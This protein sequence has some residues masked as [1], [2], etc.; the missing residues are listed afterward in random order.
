M[1]VKTL[2]DVFQAQKDQHSKGVVFIDTGDHEEYISYAE[3]FQRSLLALAYLQSEAVCPGQEL[4]FQIS[5]NKNF[6][7]LFWACI[8]GGIIPVPL[9]VGHNDEHRQKLF[10]VWRILHNPR[11]IA[12][13][14]TLDRLEKFSKI[15][16][17][18]DLFEAITRYTLNVDHLFSLKNSGTIYDATADDLAFIQFSSGST[19]DPKGVMLTHR[20][21]LTTIGAIASAANYSEDDTALSWMPLTHDMGII[22]FHINPLFSGMK[23]VLLSTDLFVRRPSRWLEKATQHRATVLCSPNFGYR[24]TLK[25]FK[26]SF[27]ST[28][29]LSAVRILYNGAEPLS[30]KLCWEFIERMQVFGLSKVAMCPVYGLA[31]ASLAVSI[32]GIQDPVNFIQVHRDYLKPG[33]AVRYTSDSLCAVSLVN[34]GRAVHG[35]H[36][37]ILDNRGLEV[38]PGVVGAVHIMGENVTSGYYNNIEETRNIFTAETWLNTGDLGCMVN[39]A[40]FI[41][42][43]A[44]DIIFLNGQNY[45]PNDLEEIAAEIQGVELNKIAI[46][47]FFNEI[48]QMEE[49]I[50]FVFYRGA[51]D[52][53]LPLLGAIKEHV[54]VKTGVVLY[55]II[56]VGDIPKTTSGKLQRYKMLQRYQEKKYVDIENRLQAMLQKHESTDGKIFIPENEWQERIFRIWLDVLD[57]MFIPKDVSFY[58]LGGDSLKAA[59]LASLLQR[60]FDVSL[61]FETLYKASTLDEFIA[62]FPTLVRKE[63]K[64]IPQDSN[65]VYFPLSSIQKQLYYNWALDSDTLAYNMPMVFECHGRP[66][67]GLLQSSLDDLIARH[68]ALRMFFIAGDDPVSTVADDLEVTISAIEAP[69]E[70]LENTLKNL[71]Q[72]FNLHAPGL[73]RASLLKSND[74]YWL[75]LDV[76]HIISDGTSANQLIGEWISLYHGKKLMPLPARYTDFLLWE[77][78]YVAGALSDDLSYWKDRLSAQFHVLELPTDHLR[79]AVFRAEGGKVRYAVESDLS[80]S[81]KEMAAKHACTLNTLLCSVYKLLLYKYTGQDDFV[82]GVPVAGRDHPDLQHLQGLFVNNLCLRN[83]MNPL[84]PFSVFLESE[85]YVFAEAFDHQRYPFDRLLEAMDLKREVSK[86]QIFDVMFVY[87]SVDLS[88][89]S[90]EHLSLKPYFL[91][92][93]VSKYDV[94]L[95][96]VETSG[97]IAY[98]I[99]YATALF[100]EDTIHRMAV[101]YMNLLRQVTTGSDLSLVALSMLSR[102][103]DN[104]FI[105]A[106]NQTDHFFP[107]EKSIVQMFEEQVCRDSQRVAVVHGAD[108]YSYEQLER[109]VR[110]LVNFFIQSGLKAREIVVIALE[111][112]FDLVASLLAV[113]KMGATYLPIDPDLPMDRIAYMIED[114]GAC[115]VICR[116]HFWQ[117]FRETGV[118]DQLITIHPENIYIDNNHHDIPS[119]TAAAMAYLMYT[120]GTTG[121]PKAVCISQ[122]AL[123]NYILSAALYYVNQDAPAF[124]L[125]TS[126]SF[127]L[128][129]TSIFTPLVTGGS[130]VVYEE[131]NTAVLIEKILSDNKVDIL[132]LTPSHLNQIRTVFSDGHTIRNKLRC[133]IVGGE[134][135]EN[136]LAAGIKKI[137][138]N[139]V[140]IFNEYGPTEATVGCMLYRYQGTEHTLGVPIG[141][142]FY[143]MQCYVLD[144]NLSLVP[145]GVVGEL[146][147]GGKGLAGGYLN[148]EARSRECFIANPFAPHSV[149]YKTGDLVRHLSNGCIEYIGRKD[150]QIK[151]NGYRI[152]PGEIQYHL[153]RFEGVKASWVG[154]RK[155]R[156]G[157]LLAAY[158]K[159]MPG[160]KQINLIEIRNYLAGK[161]PHYMVPPYLMEIDEIPLTINGKVDLDKLP[162]PYEGDMFKEDTELTETETITLAVWRNVLGESRLTVRDNFFRHGGDSIKA[163][164][165]V[166]QLRRSGLDVKVKDILTFHDVRETSRRT[167]QVPL[168]ERFE[169]GVLRGERS[170][171]PI[172]KWFFDNNFSNPHFYNQTVLLE[173]HQ[174]VDVPLL[175]QVLAILLVHHDGLRINVD[176]V[177]ERL[178]YNDTWLLS[179]VKVEEIKIEQDS[180][181]EHI[182]HNLKSQFNL[183]N[184]MLLKP[185]VIKTST[186]NYLFITAHHLVVDGVSWRVLLED[187]YQLYTRLGKERSEVILPSKTASCVQWVTRVQDVA[188]SSEKRAN[189]S[190]FQRIQQLSFRIPLD[191]QPKEWIVGDTR[192]VIYCLDRQKTAYLLKDA[193]RVYNTDVNI[194]LTTALAITLADW[195]GQPELVVEFEHHGRPHD[196]IDLSRTVGWFTVMNLVY[197]NTGVEGLERKIKLIKEQVRQM[198]RMDVAYAAWRNAY[199]SVGSSKEMTMSEVRFNYLG[200]FDSAFN[201]DLFSLSSLSTGKDADV[202]NV[203]TTKLEWNLMVINDSLQVEV[204]YNSIAHHDITIRNLLLKFSENLSMVLGHIQ[205]Q[206]DIHFTPSD[207]QAVQIDQ[208]ELDMLFP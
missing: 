136:S 139:S 172:E 133:L 16:N 72:P 69:I 73:F 202:N 33:D 196:E 60:E 55:R 18:S 109:R 134:N 192:K 9:T 140:E 128:T 29:D 80:Y 151:L 200:Q 3:L 171:L 154:L 43:R 6:V 66:D 120:S 39:D 163:M 4:V 147:V 74:S 94:T 117:V 130:I 34:V 15:H 11:M 206:G 23:Q 110:L 56:P 182:S 193:H 1:C 30:L 67:I 118:P 135:L 88:L 35:C 111:R 13:K 76:H 20:N 24:Y 14:L 204:I 186:A 8:L 185:A 143:N 101:H 52:K 178:Y 64:P 83:K 26:E 53:F 47:G 137:F 179:G 103:E 188:G 119:E 168:H 70:R 141:T 81:L 123:V 58:Q 184:T 177:N 149:L 159:T 37:S 59:E 112:S 194:V 102:E 165:I 77:K 183:H 31:E 50:A 54:S 197:L 125:F 65:E 187:L 175:E 71:I 92:P 108:V 127:D 62:V 57:R 25:H 131:A 98:Y 104:Y 201:N 170:S 51:L 107:F 84:D 153:N 189:D 32:S 167:V 150:A 85:K 75:F 180:L 155:T 156:G 121:H 5:D 79:P 93:G 158:L 145:V 169:Q 49:S 99:E 45:Y 174:Q 82:I 173:F 63:Y 166:S 78:E 90:G 91:D 191:F 7:V 21:V 61:T 116:E 176:K 198:S 129:V 205:N 114:S 146:Y 89:F 40:L 42:G 152:E 208:E 164:Q 160:S 12:D 95:E 28:L 97:E 190:F 105:T 142:P 181:P 203:L 36:I 132:K 162:D 19:G 48:T 199:K 17:K 100:N 10:N 148:N 161:L 87:R 68:D 46:A 115:G 22:G 207:F 195:V 44:K 126:I 124:A 157:V 113:F 86:H 138:S 27:S 144:V 2:V 41:T 96:V 122:P 106:F 38:V